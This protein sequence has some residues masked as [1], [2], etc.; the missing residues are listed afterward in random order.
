MEDLNVFTT[1]ESLRKRLNENDGK[2]SV[3]LVPTMGA[4]HH[5]HLEL[6]KKAMLLANEVVVSI[7]VNPTQF[8]KKEDLDNYP[9]TLENDVRLL[10]TVGNIIVFAPP[11][12]EVY[13]E[14]Y[15]AVTL[16]LGDLEH[17]M[18]GE[19]R[20][21][22]FN[23][24][25]NVCKRLIEIVDPEYSLFGLKDFQQL[26]VINFMVKS[27][28]LGT[29]IV[30]CEIVR[31]TSGLASSSRNQRLSEQE[32]EDAIIIHEM[33]VLL[34][35]LAKR[36]SPKEAKKIALEFFNRGELKLEYLNIVHPDT[37]LEI[38]QWVPGARSCLAAYCGEVRLIDNME[39]IDSGVNS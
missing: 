38:D 30:P 26:A 19:F 23:G 18:E 39:L 14:D 37:L 27:F 1:V 24:V 8:N 33:M 31:E 11:V 34:K 21:G 4:L 15:E 7:F 13:P 10:K 20:P 3:A 29:K 35:A 6:V 9:R 36:F 32:K 17:V 25:V 16:D 22:H 12:S 5:G 28:N 2:S